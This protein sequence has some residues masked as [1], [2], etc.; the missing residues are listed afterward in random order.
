MDA[1]SCWF[2]NAD[3]V[4]GNTI[5]GNLREGIIVLGES[6]TNLVRNV[7]VDNP[8]G[9]ACSRIAS[10]GQAAESPSGAPKI[11]GNFF[12]RNPTEVQ[13]SDGTAKPLPPDN[14]IADPKVSD[15][16]NNFRLAADSP[17]RQANAGAADPIALASPFAIQA[18]EISMIPDSDS[19]DFSLWKK[20]TAA[21]K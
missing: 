18:G 8:I 12:F 16:Q 4:E 11:A 6:R 15:A 2:N 13:A 5:I 20:A 21:P 14:R 9:V 3:N 7:F 1:M 17:A 10:S 19:R